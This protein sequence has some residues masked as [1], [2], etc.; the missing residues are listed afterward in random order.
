MSRRSFNG[1]R[2]VILE[3]RPR[4]CRSCTTNCVNWRRRRG[5]EHLDVAAA[6]LDLGRVLQARGGFEEAEVVLSEA[7]EIRQKLLGGGDRT[8]AYIQGVLDAVRKQQTGSGPKATTLPG[9]RPGG[10]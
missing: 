5:N 4:C 8:V 6:L 9:Q 3:R 2:R 7:L 1:W 10:R